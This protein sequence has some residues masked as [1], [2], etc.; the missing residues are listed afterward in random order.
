MTDCPNAEIR[1]LLPDYVHDQLNATDFARVEQHVASCADCAEEVALLQTVLAI[2][3]KVRV[4]NIA[5]I[6]ASL[7]KPGQL[8][9]AA[10]HDNVRVA[11]VEGVRDISTAKSVARKSRTFGNWRAIA[12]VAVMAVGAT[13]LPM[14]PWRI[15][16]T[17]T[18]PTAMTATAA[19]ARQ[20]PNVR[21]LRATLLAVEMSRTPSTAA[22]RTLSVNATCVS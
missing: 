15:I 8:T 9:H 1:D 12:A 7:P 10:L 13:V 22:T 18:A 6:L 16:V 19:I 17:E 14:T 20:L 21:L 3:P 4:P 11:A 5:D 2:R